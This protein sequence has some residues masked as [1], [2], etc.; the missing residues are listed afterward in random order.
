MDQCEKVAF[1]LA[2]MRKIISTWNIKFKEIT[3]VYLSAGF[4]RMKD[5]SYH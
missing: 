4:S 2:K 1:H 5:C 3:Y